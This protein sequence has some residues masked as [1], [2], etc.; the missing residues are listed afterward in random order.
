MYQRM[1]NYFENECCIENIFMKKYWYIWYIILI[2]T[3][4]ICV[5]FSMLKINIL[6]SLAIV[7]AIWIAFSIFYFKKYIRELQN[8]LQGEKVK[9]NWLAIFTRQR[10]LPAYFEFQE[11]KLSDYFRTH[12]ITN[13]D[14]EKFLM[15]INEDLE[16]KYPQSRIKEN[17]LN[18]IVPMTVA[19]VSIYLT[20]SEAKDLGIIINT[21]IY[22]I[23]Y[24]GMV[25]ISI[26]GVSR[27][28]R[29]LVNS[30]RNLLDLKEVLRN[31]Q[32]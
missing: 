4:V 15:Y 12:N 21:I 18:V 30:R 5:I 14:K 9:I 22:A 29:M 25:T 16:N 6:I 26:Y 17:F 3:I 2:S 31:I 20:N 8:E 32:I 23:I 10:F 27:I 28:G 13:E 7:F 24:A 11:K 1:L 19:V